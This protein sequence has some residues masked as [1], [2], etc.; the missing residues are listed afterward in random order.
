MIY[1]NEQWENADTLD[2][3]IAI[4]REQ[5][6]EELASALKEIGTPSKNMENELDILQSQVDEFDYDNQCLEDQVNDL[7][8]ENDR[9]EDKINDLEEEIK[10][11]S[12]GV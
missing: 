6:S 5:F 3:I 7:L 8:E 2:N 10:D 11:L 9:L 4:I 12:G 1:I